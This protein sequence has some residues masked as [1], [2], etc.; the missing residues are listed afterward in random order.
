MSHPQLCKLWLALASLPLPCCCTS[1]VSAVASACQC[2]NSKLCQNRKAACRMRLSGKGEVLLCP[3]W[4]VC[5]LP[6]SVL[7]SPGIIQVHKDPIAPSQVI[8]PHTK[9]AG[10]LD[11]A[12]LKARITDATRETQGTFRASNRNVL[13]CASDLAASQRESVTVCRGNHSQALCAMVERWVRLF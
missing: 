10:I 1:L 13:P 11:T 12:Q 7:Q 8:Q 3:R 4:N 6:R 9:T 2:A 5:A